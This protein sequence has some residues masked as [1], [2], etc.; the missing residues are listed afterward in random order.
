MNNKKQEYV[1]PE[2]IVTV[3]ADDVITLS[4]DKISWEG[5]IVGA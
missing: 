4:E 1:S 5:P 3:V 2:I